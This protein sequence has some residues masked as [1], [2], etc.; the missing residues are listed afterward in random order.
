MGE[1]EALPPRSLLWDLVVMVIGSQGG[2]VDGAGCESSGEKCK[3]NDE[4]GAFNDSQT[5]VRRLHSGCK[6]DNLC[7]L[8]LQMYACISMY[9][10][11][12]GVRVSVCVYVGA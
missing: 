3:E 8:K 12:C 10:M 6:D 9:C 7:S 11:A 1:E 4:T 2:Q 5:D